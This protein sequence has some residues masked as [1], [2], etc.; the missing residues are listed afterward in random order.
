M[1]QIFGMDELDKFISA[2]NLP[3]LPGVELEKVENL[4]NRLSRFTPV[5]DLVPAFYFRE[6]QNEAVGFEFMESDVV[7]KYGDTL[8][9]AIASEKGTSFKFELI[10]G[11]S[12]PYLEYLSDY[13]LGLKSPSLVIVCTRYKMDCWITYL[14]QREKICK[15]FIAKI[16]ERVKDFYTRLA[17]Y[18]DIIQWGENRK[19]GV[20]CRGG[21]KF[22]F[23]ISPSGLIFQGIDIYTSSGDLQTFLEMSENKYI[24]PVLSEE[25]VEERDFFSFAREYISSSRSFKVYRTYISSLQKYKPDVR[26]EDLNMIFFKEF[27]DYLV[28]TLS[29]SESTVNNMFSFFKKLFK[30]AVASGYLENNPLQDFKNNILPSR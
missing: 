14:T 19:S 28:N 12:S 8:L 21:L 11:V 3:S 7:L 25:R 27:S 29:R 13:L 24:Q 10:G 6:R 4:K 5:C 17:P 16:E 18:N 2:N 20:L 9:K 22:T 23:T 30:V 26:F 15:E 1:K